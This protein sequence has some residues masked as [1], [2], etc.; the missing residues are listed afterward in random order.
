MEITYEVVKNLQPEENVSVWGC[1]ACCCANYAA[2][3]AFGNSI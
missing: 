2:H 3:S 1:F